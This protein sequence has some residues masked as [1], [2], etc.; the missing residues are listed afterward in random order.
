MVLSF[1]LS[2]IIDLMNYVKNEAFL[3]RALEKFIERLFNINRS[4]LRKKY[5]RA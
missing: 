2:G 5:P 1:C 3:F 4:H